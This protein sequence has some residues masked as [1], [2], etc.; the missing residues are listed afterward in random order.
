[1]DVHVFGPFEVSS[2]LIQ[3]TV[4]SDDFRDLLCFF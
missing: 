3:D 1:M 4:M 2:C